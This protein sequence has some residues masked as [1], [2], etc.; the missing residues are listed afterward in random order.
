MAEH[1]SE[2]TDELKDFIIR[3]KIYFVASADVQGRVNV[4]PKGGDT[5]RILSPNRVV[6]LNLTGSSNE[7]AAH[8]KAVNRITLMFCSFDRQPLILRLYGQAQLVHSRGPHWDELLNLF[9]DATGAR[10]IFDVSIDLVQT[11]CGFQVPF[12][13]YKGERETLRNW[14]AKKNP[15]ELEKYWKENNITSLDGK[16]TGIESGVSDSP[17]TI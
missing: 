17:K 3:Q 10:Q 7:T 11:S 16:P 9:P 15:D 2:I 6:W 4:S 5:L 8:I 14:A 1:F 13:E 12:F